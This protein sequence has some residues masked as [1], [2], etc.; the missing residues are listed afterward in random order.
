[1][2]LQLLRFPTSKEVDIWE[3]NE[4]D[5]MAAYL[6]VQPYVLIQLKKE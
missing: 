1:M 6:I 2:E 3:L 4:N 5:E